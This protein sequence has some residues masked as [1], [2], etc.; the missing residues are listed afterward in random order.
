MQSSRRAVWK[1]PPTAFF[2]YRPFVSQ[3][4]ISEAGDSSPKIVF[5]SKDASIPPHICPKAHVPFLSVLN[6]RKNRNIRKHGK[7]NFEINVKP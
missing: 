3:G 5:N 7:D 4:K 6:K 1:R 2:C